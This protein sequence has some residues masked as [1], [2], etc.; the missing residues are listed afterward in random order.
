MEER[1][2]L[3]VCVCVRGEFV[4]VGVR[5]EEKGGERESGCGC[6]WREGRQVERGREG[7]RKRVRGGNSGWS[8]GEL[9]GMRC[10]R[11]RERG[12]FYL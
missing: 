5:G 11:G 2:C 4:R 7:E 3:C 12:L 6:E 1:K 9:V 10:R 8:T